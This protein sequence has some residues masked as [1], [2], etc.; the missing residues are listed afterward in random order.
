MN[1]EKGTIKFITPTPVGQE[2]EKKKEPN[3]EDYNSREMYAIED[4]K[5]NP[6]KLVIVLVILA[7]IIYIIVTKTL[8][9]LDQLK[10]KNPEAFINLLK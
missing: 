3:H 8:P 4:R 1:N 10:P 7:I 5:I 2:E 9:M 6:V